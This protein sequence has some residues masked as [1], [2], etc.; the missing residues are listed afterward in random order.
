MNDDSDAVLLRRYLGDGDEAAFAEVVRRYVGLVYHAALRQ[1]G[2]DAHAAEDIAQTVFTLAARKAASLVRHETLAG[3]LYTTT[4]YTA[5]VHRRREIRRIRREEELVIMHENTV[6]ETSQDWERLR[7]LIDDVLTDLS[8]A[9]RDAILLRFFAGRPFAEIGAR[10]SVSENA[11]RMRVERAL[12]KLHGLLARRGVASTAT[13]LGVALTTQAMASA[14]AGLAVSVT[15]AALAGSA[16]AGAWVTAGIFVMKTK[17][18]VLGSVALFAAGVA[19]FQYN[20]AQNAEVLL[21]VANRD[22]DALRERLRDAPP[23]IAVGTGKTMGAPSVVKAGL[24]APAS[25]A[26]PSS[27]PQ[28]PP[29]TIKMGKVVPGRDQSLDSQYR[30]LYRVLGLTDEQSAKFKAIMVENARRNEA[31]MEAAKGKN[32]KIDPAVQR[33]IDDQTNSELIAAIRAEFGESAVEAM[34]RHERTIPFRGPLDDLA[35]SLFYTD[36]PLTAA[37]AEQLLDA[38]ARQERETTGKL[39]FDRMVQPDLFGAILGQSP[40]IL[41]D[42]Q[43]EALRQITEQSLEQKRAI[44]KK[45]VSI[46]GNATI[47]SV[48]ITGSAATRPRS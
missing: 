24:N 41:S 5:Q 23:T 43:V 27:N 22:R 3:W 28:R 39:D 45:A 37:Q 13:A 42:P 38:V 16:T 14:P 19:V 46:M 15:G 26:A 9:D 10:L 11:A 17:T 7:P 35:K 30:P 33:A 29:I 44:A 1:A 12:E 47:Q 18:I 40:G 32:P 20:Q 4:R 34:D 8:A 25:S 2:G 31:L 48:P 21:A 36:T 6:T